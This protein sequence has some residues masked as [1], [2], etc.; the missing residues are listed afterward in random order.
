MAMVQPEPVDGKSP[1]NDIEPERVVEAE[2]AHLLANVASWTRDPSGRS[3][4]Q[5]HDDSRHDH[6]CVEDDANLGRHS[7]TEIPAIGI[8]QRQDYEVRVEERNH[9]AQSR[10]SGKQHSVC[11]AAPP[12]A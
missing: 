4:D 9:A 11:G 10:A 12:I 5:V 6:R 1:E 8:E 3:E 2:M 7:P